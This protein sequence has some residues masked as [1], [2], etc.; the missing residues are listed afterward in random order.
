MEVAA[1]RR[2]LSQREGGLEGRLRRDV[3]RAAATAGRRCAMRRGQP[4]R[5]SP[6]RLKQLAKQPGLHAD[7]GGLYL[8]V[9]RNKNT[10]TL[11]QS[12]VFLYVRHGER[13]MIGGGSMYTVSLADARE[14]ARK[15][16]MLLVE[17]RDP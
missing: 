5:L 10:G 6:L 11:R 7:G 8:A 16:R 3:R 17:G 9:T 2:R 1:D 12:W 4:G 15:Q 14:W 13:H